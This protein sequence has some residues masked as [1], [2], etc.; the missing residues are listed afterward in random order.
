V[1]GRFQRVSNVDLDTLTAI[2]ES[3]RELDEMPVVANVS[4]GHTTPGF[5]F[6]IGGYGRVR[7]AERRVELWIDRH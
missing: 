7:T 2:I 4:F 3:K 6:P 1:I 5:T